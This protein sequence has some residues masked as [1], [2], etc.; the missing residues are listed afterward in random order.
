MNRN[1]DL[2]ATILAELEETQE[3]LRERGPLKP[4]GDNRP[5][6]EGYM[7]RIE[8]GVGY[9]YFWAEAVHNNGTDMP[10]RAALDFK[11]DWSTWGNNACQFDQL[12]RGTLSM[13]PDQLDEFL[14]E[15]FTDA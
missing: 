4:G 1:G 7:A 13:P 3:A 5:M 11:R 15:L 8:E 6:E 10:P 12:V 2:T 14:A 9:S